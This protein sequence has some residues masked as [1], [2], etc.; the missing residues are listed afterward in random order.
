VVENASIKVFSPPERTVAYK[1]GYGLLFVLVVMGSFGGSTNEFAIFILAVVIYVLALFLP[2]SD[3]TMTITAQS[4]VSSS[5]R[6]RQVIPIDEIRI[7]KVDYDGNNDICLFIETNQSK[8]YLGKDLSSDQIKEAVAYILEQIKVHY[9]VNY[10]DVK[11]EHLRVEQFW[12][13]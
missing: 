4:V 13:K 11:I 10:E 1:V 6:S 12:R 7:V 9:P 5:A 8:F 2:S 3:A